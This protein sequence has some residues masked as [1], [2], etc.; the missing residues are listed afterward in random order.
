MRQVHARS[1]AG[2]SASG[3]AEEAGEGREAAA[4]V[5]LDAGVVRQ[6]GGATGGC[7]GGCTARIDCHACFR[8]CMHTCFRTCMHACTRTVGDAPQ[9]RV[10]RMQVSLTEILNLQVLQMRVLLAAAAAADAAAVFVLNLCAGGCVAAALRGQGRGGGRRRENDRFRCVVRDGVGVCA[11][12][13]C[14]C[15]FD[16]V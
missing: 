2:R 10:G 8:A 7:R 13:L 3:V 5:L 1:V 15:V 16:A 11:A 4:A 12:R 6:D 9:V 14:V